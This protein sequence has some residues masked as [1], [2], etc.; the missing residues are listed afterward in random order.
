MYAPPTSS[1]LIKNRELFLLKSNL[2][3][4]HDHNKMKRIKQRKQQ[5][6]FLLF[7]QSRN[8]LL[9][10]SFCARTFISLPEMKTRTKIAEHRHGF[11]SVSLHVPC[12]EVLSALVSDVFVG[13]LLYMK[14][15]SLGSEVRTTPS[16]G[17]CGVADQVDP[18]SSGISGTLRSPG[19]RQ[20]EI[21]AT[22]FS[23]ILLF[24]VFSC[25]FWLWEGWVGKG[26]A[27]WKVEGLSPSCSFRSVFRGFGALSE[28]IGS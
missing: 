2:F 3:R 12:F 24:C 21:A 27:G 25:S 15:L 18:F 9:S 26:C 23:F 22:F 4:F 19:F 20:W 5:K 17:W 7:I 8:E 6:Q 13:L 11:L 16:G 1:L 10:Y 14:V 28:S